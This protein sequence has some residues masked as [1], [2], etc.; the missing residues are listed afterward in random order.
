ML[1]IRPPPAGPSSVF[2]LATPQH[3]LAKLAWEIRQLGE[4]LAPNDADFVWPL[5]PAYH[6]YNSAVTAWHLVDWIW[7][8]ADQK[9]RAQLAEKFHFDIP[10]SARKG[11]ARFSD[12]IAR[13]CRALHLC[14]IIANGSKH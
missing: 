8:T 7:C 5:V 9:L 13:D 3:M 4:S 10:S 11:L 14:R 12:S 2:A 1:I 6:A